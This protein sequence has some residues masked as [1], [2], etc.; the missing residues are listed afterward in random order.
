MKYVALLGEKIIDIAESETVPVY[1]PTPE[2]RSVETVRVPEGIYPQLGLCFNGTDLYDEE[3]GE[4]VIRTADDDA[5]KEE[6][7]AGEPTQLD[8]IEAN[9]DYLVL[10]NS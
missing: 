6:T 8:R 9:M 3:T 1:P 10:L 7:A 5:Q 4:I 2:G